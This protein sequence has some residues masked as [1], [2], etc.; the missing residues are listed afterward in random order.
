MR[1]VFA[2]FLVVSEIVGRTDRALNYFRI[3]TQKRKTHNFSLHFA[4]GVVVFVFAVFFEID[5]VVWPT[6]C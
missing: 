1:E 2:K 6:N 5:A 4:P 3:Q